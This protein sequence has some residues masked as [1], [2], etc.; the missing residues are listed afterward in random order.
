MSGFDVFCMRFAL[1]TFAC[2]AAGL[3][4]G[5]VSAVCRRYL[6]VLALQRSVW[7][8]G[9]LAIAATFLLMLM[10][11]TETLRVVPA[12]E[13]SDMAP[14][15]PVASERASDAGVAAPASAADLP[16]RDSNWL[17]LGA[18]GWLAVYAV[19]LLVSAARVL[20]SQYAVD[21]LAG[22]GAVLDRLDSHAGFTGAAAPPVIE[23]DAAISPMLCG[24]L[25]PRL[26]LPRHL[27][28]FDTIQQ[29]LIVAHELTHWRRGDLRWMGAAVALQTVFWFHPVMRLLRANLSW[30]QELA[31]DRDVLAGRP[32][33]ERKAYASAL[34]AQLKTQQRP[35]TVLAF[36][37]ASVDTLASRIGLIRAPLASARDAITRW[38]ALSALMAV[39]A[40]NLA[41]QPALAWR[42]PDSAGAAAQAAAADTPLDCT[43]LVDAAS[44]RRLRQSGDCDTRITPA[45]T[46]NI[47]VSLM[48]FDSGI[49]RDA[50]TPRL[51]YRANAGYA[52]W[53][54][55]WRR[56]TDPTSWIRN[57]NVWY[58]QHVTA[59]LGEERLAR[60]L[61]SFNYGNRDASG[62]PG[63]HNGLTMSWIS[64]SMQ[65]S[66]VE[67]VAFLRGVVNR[68]L[69]LSAHA[70]DMTA[71]V[72]KLPAG[73][74]WTAY[75]KTGTSSPVLADG[76]LDTSRQYGWFVGWATKG[77]RT[78]VFARLALGPTSGDSGAGPRL[79]R[80]F[81]R[82]L[83]A[84]F[85]SL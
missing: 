68:Q 6:P 84:H 80:Q 30:A 67:Q 1:A 57:S 31:C 40:A 7:L 35:A 69:P 24:L 41:L 15:A 5:V 4:I 56:D 75:G 23:V 43:L 32:Q 2:L 47:A 70:Y 12:I 63:K 46:F 25:K 45:S 19:G 82:D 37:G 36:G 55:S 8:L 11:Q 13:V 59:Q 62:D 20:R 78:V 58:A 17:L 73:G 66:P 74:G 48:G 10:P 29:Q 18:Q 72:L 77:G 16:A 54:T 50:H 34:L 33:A 64:S 71:Q 65:I 76:T 44:G 83:P 79:R 22:S 26:L 81:L 51:P 39:F 85:D 38:V 52:D 61:D 49:L 3:G 9:Q 21:S 28:S 53:N 60:Y 14:V 42:A 27:R